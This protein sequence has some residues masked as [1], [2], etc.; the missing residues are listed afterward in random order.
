MVEMRHQK[1]DTEIFTKEFL[2][3]NMRR[4]KYLTD[5][6]KIKGVWYD[7]GIDGG[8]VRDY[9]EDY[10]NVIAY[11]YNG[12]LNYKYIF[13]D[14][15][16]N[17]LDS[18]E[19]DTITHFEVIEHLLNPL[20]NMTECYRILKSGGKMYLTTPNDYSLIH[21]LEHLL[22]IQYEPH[23]HQFNKKGLLWLLEEAGFKDIKITTFKKSS[24]GYIARWC[25]NSFF[26]EATK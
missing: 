3:N 25:R 4:L 15:S 26:V 9:L 6:V 19:I 22:S 17:V 5:N 2:K 12:D 24:K 20:L 7:V 21:K 10:Y 18:D 16:C 13:E 11:T 8:V 14:K 23:F 1:K